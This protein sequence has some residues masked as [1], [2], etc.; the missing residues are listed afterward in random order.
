MR[1]EN[2]RTLIGIRARPVTTDRKMLSYAIRN[3]WHGL[4]LPICNALIVS[5]TVNFG[6]CQPAAFSFQP[7]LIGLLP[8]LETP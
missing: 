1:N 5:N 8:L 7:I 3:R 2:G 4:W 6:K